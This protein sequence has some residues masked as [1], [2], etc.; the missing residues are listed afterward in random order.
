MG[1]GCGTSASRT[2][3][4]P[5]VVFMD[6]HIYTGPWWYISW[7]IYIYIQV[8]G[9]MYHGPIYIYRPMVVC[10]MDLHI[11]VHGRIYHVSRF[12]LAVRR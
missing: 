5:T 4:Q 1:T 11:Q 8:H 6:L 3:T 9:R 12:G 10:I 2:C 7:T